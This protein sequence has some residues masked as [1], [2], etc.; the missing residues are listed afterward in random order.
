M[1]VDVFFRRGQLA[2]LDLGQL[3][4]YPNLVHPR[5][6]IV[7]WHLVH[8]ME[9]GLLMTAHRFLSISKDQESC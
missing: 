8:E 4:C 7:G 9:K 5:A 1:L 3:R 2:S 6:D